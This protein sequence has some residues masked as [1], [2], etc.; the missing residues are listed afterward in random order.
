MRTTNLLAAV[1]T[2]LTTREARAQ[3]AG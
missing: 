3:C 1:A 2:L